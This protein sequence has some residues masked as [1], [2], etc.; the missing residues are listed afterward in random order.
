MTKEL[1]DRLLSKVETVT[2]SGCWI[3]TGFCNPKGY[4][5]MM[6]NGRCC[7]AHR[8]SNEH[9]VGP[10]Q[11]GLTLDHLCRVRSCINPDHLQPVSNKV[12]ILRGHGVG[13]VNA[14]KTHCPN[15]HEYIEGQVYRWNGK[16][17]CLLCKRDRRMAIRKTNAEA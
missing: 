14:G 11:D 16:R 5:Q 1:C 3:W 10:I 17:H 8:V 9:F 2:E 12:N 4:G 13:V 6:V 7:R 15:G